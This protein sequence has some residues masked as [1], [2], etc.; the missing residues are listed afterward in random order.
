MDFLREVFASYPDQVIVIRLT[1]SQT[2]QFSFTG[3][4]NTPHTRRT[5]SAAG[6]D[7]I[8]DARVNDDPN[9]RRQSVSDI[10]FQARTRVRVEGS[11]KIIA[12]EAPSS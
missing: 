12:S 4:Y 7:L 8:L 10:E 2:G 3:S 11:S 1:A 9:S 6:A 5:I